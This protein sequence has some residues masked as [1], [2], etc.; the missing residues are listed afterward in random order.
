[1][2]V[3][4]NPDLESELSNPKYWDSIR[5]QRM[6]KKRLIG[7]LPE[8]KLKNEV[9]DKMKVVFGD[10]LRN[11]LIV[12][13]E[14]VTPCKMTGLN[15]SHQRTGS[16]FISEASIRDLPQDQ[17]NALKVE[18]LTFRYMNE[19]KDIQAYYIA[20]N[21]RNRYYAIKKQSQAAKPL[22]NWEHQESVV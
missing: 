9:K 12:H 2:I 6:K 19:P 16:I 11:H 5:K 13:G 15:I 10:M 3:F 7:R 4:D 20:H 8:S 22:F 1:L 18:F 14:S 21:I 17:F